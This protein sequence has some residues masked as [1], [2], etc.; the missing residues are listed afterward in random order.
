MGFSGLMMGC[1]RAYWANILKLIYNTYGTGNWSW[2]E[3]QKKYPEITKSNLSR[4][5]CSEWIK[6]SKEQ[7]VIKDKTGKKQ[8]RV[9][10][11]HLPPEAVTIC[12]AA[13]KPKK[14]VVKRC[15]C[16]KEVRK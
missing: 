16:K 6:K 8:A 5:K 13:P 2:G 11:W 4:L 7:R 3:L 14:V 1:S 10:L 15:V 9:V 12:R